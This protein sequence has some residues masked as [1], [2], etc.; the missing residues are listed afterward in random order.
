MRIK[1]DHCRTAVVVQWLSPPANAGD[2]GSI[3][4][5][6]R[7]HLSRVPCA[8][9]TEPVHFRAYGPREKPPQSEAHVPQRESRPRL[10]EREKARTAVKT[11]QSLNKW[12]N[13]IVKPKKKNLRK[14]KRLKK[15]RERS[16]QSQKESGRIKSTLAWCPAHTKHSV[17]TQEVKAGWILFKN[18]ERN[19]NVQLWRTGY[20]YTAERN[21]RQILPDLEFQYKQYSH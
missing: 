13:K 5:L 9:T 14:E 15:E 10:P 20:T 12:I 19:Q 1:R 3:P 2:M 6:G 4:S 17:N 7:F 21:K 18:M 8:T 16:L 11:Q